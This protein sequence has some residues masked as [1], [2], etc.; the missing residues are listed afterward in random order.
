[1]S[2]VFHLKFSYVFPVVFG[3]NFPFKI[4]IIFKYVGSDRLNR[5]EHVYLDT[6][7]VGAGIK[8]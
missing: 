4:N 2:N 1:M 6:S 3:I 7:T 8:V 5:W